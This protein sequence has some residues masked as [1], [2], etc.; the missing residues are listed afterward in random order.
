MWFP[1]S[2]IDKFGGIKFFGP[3]KAYIKW[4]EF[5]IDSQIFV[6][7]L[8]ERNTQINITWFPSSE[9]DKTGGSNFFGPSKAYIKRQNIGKRSGT[10]FTSILRFFVLFLRHGNA[11]ISLPPVPASTVVKMKESYRE[12]ALSQA[13]KPTQSMSVRLLSRNLFKQW[14]LRTKKSV[15]SVTASRITT[16]HAN[17][18]GSAHCT[19]LNVCVSEFGGQK[20][21]F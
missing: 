20:L 12:T 6:F 16:H 18:H 15:S 4:N 10:I 2:E 8:E 21:I 13:Q 19:C 5:Y 7:F 1:C 14:I 11:G 9:I 3:R 17:H